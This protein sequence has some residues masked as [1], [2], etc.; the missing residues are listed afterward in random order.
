M[1]VYFI[2]LIFKWR[3]TLKINVQVSILDLVQIQSNELHQLL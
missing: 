3:F 1:K 2:Y